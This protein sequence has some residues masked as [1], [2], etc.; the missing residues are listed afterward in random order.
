MII[1]FIFLLY[2]LYHI[3]KLQYLQMNLFQEFIGLEMKKYENDKTKIVL[4][5]TLL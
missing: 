5:L 3:L 4:K 2:I 1:T